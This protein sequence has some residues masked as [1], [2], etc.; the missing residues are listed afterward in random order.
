MG[1]KIVAKVALFSCLLKYYSKKNMH[2]R[3]F[4]LEYRQLQRQ[5]ALIYAKS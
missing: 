1:F 5:F 2:F 3:M 4:F